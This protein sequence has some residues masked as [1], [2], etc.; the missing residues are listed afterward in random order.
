MYKNR[1]LVKQSELAFWLCRKNKISTEKHFHQRQG[2]FPC[3]L[4]VSIIHFRWEIKQPTAIPI[5]NLEQIIGKFKAPFK[6]PPRL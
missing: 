3:P 6:N 4:C 2:I 1:Y 5:L